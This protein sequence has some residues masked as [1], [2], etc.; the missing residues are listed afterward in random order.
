VFKERSLADGS[1]YYKHRIYGR[2]AYM[3]E[4]REPEWLP[5]GIKT[6]A[7][8]AEA[9]QECKHSLEKQPASLRVISCPV[10]KEK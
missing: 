5:V 4:N 10:P 6:F 9:V 8:A 1:I 3:P 7:D 2:A